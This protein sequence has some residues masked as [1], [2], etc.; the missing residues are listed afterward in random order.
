MG[1]VG[2]GSG[3]RVNLLQG[4]AVGEGLIYYSGARGKRVNY[5]GT[6]LRAVGKGLF[7]YSETH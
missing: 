6:P 3:E 1:R 4:T 2:R 7:Y 5:S